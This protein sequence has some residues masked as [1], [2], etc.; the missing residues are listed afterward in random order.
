MSEELD[1]KKATAARRP[2]GPIPMKAM[3]VDHEK[4]TSALQQTNFH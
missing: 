3:K 1:D 4:R 2:G